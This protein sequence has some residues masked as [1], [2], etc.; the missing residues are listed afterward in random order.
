MRY[1]AGV[2]LAIVLGIALRAP[3]LQGRL[4]G[5]DWDHFAMVHGQYPVQRSSLGLYNFAAGDVAERRALM[6]SGRLPWWTAPNFHLA[7][8][9]PLSSALLFFDHTVIG[10]ASPE[11][12]HWHSALW[13]TASLIALAGLLGRV[14]P[15]P[16]A[17]IAVLLYAVDDAQTLP[18]TWNAN[19]TALVAVA[20]ML[21]A[22]WAHIAWT[23]ERLRSQRIAAWFLLTG[24]IFAGEYALG[25]VA[26]FIAHALCDEPSDARRRL[27]AL[28]P[29][30]VPVAAYFVARSSLGYGATGSSFYVDPLRQP[31]EYLEASVGR[32]PLLLGDLLFGYTAEWWYGMPPFALS[33]LQRGVLPAAWFSLAALHALQ[34]SVGCVA[35]LLVVAGFWHFSRPAGASLSRSVAWLILGALL[36]LFPLCGVF[37]MSRLTI[38]PAV[39][40]HATLAWIVVHAWR[41]M[42]T[43]GALWI[44]CGAAGT[45]VLIVAVHCVVAALRSHDAVS[46]WAAI[47]RLEED[48]VRHAAI[49]S[50]GLG[51]RHII[52]VSAQDLATQYAL[53]YVRHL[54]RLTTPAS[55]EILLPPCMSTIDLVRVAAN[56]LDIRLSTRFDRSS[57]RRNVYWPAADREFQAG[58]RFATERFEVR[59]I[60]TEHG[61]PTQ[62]RFAFV[63]PL[64][65]PQY[66]FLYPVRDGL[67]PLALPAVG[68]TLQLAAPSFVA[69][70]R[71]N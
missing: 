12:H 22:L 65:D 2:A 6:S 29:F 49:D 44:R 11:R 47:S 3:A 19:R 39:G 67:R 66:L 32:V 55:S 15:K 28:L 30:T 13:W 64:D 48:W 27:R 25:L 52:V 68:A 5:D 46:S 18:F 61:D 69:A 17:L 42:T 43:P 1:W 33:V 51:D 36:S 41:R 50:A 34:M 7:F 24:G 10:S 23:Q 58:Q 62:L 9:R 35:L 38:G 60:A 26:Y 54:H 37:P 31:V 40:V 45:I 63:H 8:L 59:V 53:P 56:V 16:V 21:G 70:L 57:F 14:L 71:P 4:L 20:L